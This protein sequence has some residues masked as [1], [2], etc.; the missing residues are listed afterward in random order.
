MVKESKK[1]HRVTKP[2]KKNEDMTP[3]PAKPEV[4]ELIAH[5]LRKYYDAVAAQP[6]PDRFLDLLSQLETA[7]AQKKQ[8]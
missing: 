7:S 3:V 1:K 4:S 8:D 6:V 2:G 5:R